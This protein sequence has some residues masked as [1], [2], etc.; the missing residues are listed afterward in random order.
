MGK[1]KGPAGIAA[2]FAQSLLDLAVERGVEQ[3]IAADLAGVAQAIEQTPGLR[4]FLRN[5]G[6][7]AA[8][9]RTL[10]ARAFDGRVQPLLTHFIQVLAM[11]GR[12][13][14]LESVAESYARLMDARSGRVD[15]DVTVAASLSGE[16]L[17]AVRARVSEA[18]G[19]HAVVRQVVDPAVIGGL[20]LRVGDQLID[21]SV[22][23]QLSRLRQQMLSAGA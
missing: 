23:G 1:S 12:L 11:R 21:G 9:R 6:I 19:K 22:R 8:D 2:A 3:A 18:L 7:A 10:L 13:G 16:Q 17:E 4:E 15:V 5:P 14:D 20:V